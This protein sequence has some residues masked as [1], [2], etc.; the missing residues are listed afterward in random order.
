M[1]NTFPSMTSTLHKSLPIDQYALGEEQQS[2][3]LVAL[4]SATKLL[5][6]ASTNTVRPIFKN[7]SLAIN[8]GDRIGLFSSEN[9]ESLTLINCLAG[10]TPLDKG[11]LIQN[12]AIS[13]PLG[14]NDTLDSKLSGYANAQFAVELYGKPGFANEELELILELSGLSREQFHQPYGTYKGLEKDHFKLSLSLAF[15][16][17]CYLIGRIGCWKQKTKDQKSPVV[18]K[19]MREKLEGKALAIS[20]ANQAVFAFRYCTKGVAIVDGSIVYSG[21]PE[22][23]LEIIREHRQTISDRQQSLQGEEPDE[24]P[25]A[26]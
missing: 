3:P 6:N 10:I 1:L 8:P 25:Q 22:V 4:K 13:W 7:L 14:A 19:Y 12:G 15:D 18:L 2:S 11:K 17:D 9:I 5:T 26:D 21:D 23:C 24:E 20:S 16:F